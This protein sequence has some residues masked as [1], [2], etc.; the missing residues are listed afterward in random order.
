M[1]FIADP[2]PPPKKKA[3]VAP[4]AIDAD[5]FLDDVPRA[6]SAKDI[7][8]EEISNLAK[9][10]ADQGIPDWYGRSRCRYIR[11]G[12]ISY[13]C[14]PEKFAAHYAKFPESTRRGRRSW[15]TRTYPR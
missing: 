12:C 5:T 6:V 3:K 2:P 4:L 10:F 8:L 15:S 14:N 7:K 9:R 1:E 11:S 13:K